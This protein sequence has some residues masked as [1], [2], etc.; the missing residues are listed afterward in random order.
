MSMMSHPSAGLPSWT[1]LKGSQN[2]QTHKMGEAPVPQTADDEKGMDIQ[3][4]QN[5]RP[6]M[7]GADSANAFSTSGAAGSE[8]A[9]GGLSAVADLAIL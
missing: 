5:G 2:S 9:A 1:G 7:T 8:A 3:G 6:V 4:A